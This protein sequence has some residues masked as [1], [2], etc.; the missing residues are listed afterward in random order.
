MSL[1]N[2]IL[3]NN[4]KNLPNLV[5]NSNKNG[6]L[7]QLFMKAGTTRDPKN[8]VINMLQ[9]GSISKENFEQVKQI[10]VN[11]GISEQQFNQLERFLK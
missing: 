7:L 3:G 5:Q 9:S 4:N 8:A 10:A 11:L 6:Q 2:N 1:L